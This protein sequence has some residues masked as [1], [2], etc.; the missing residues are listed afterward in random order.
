MTRTLEAI[1][2]HPLQLLI[3]I[4]LPPI[5]AVAVA[6]FMTP[7]TY[8]ST[9]SVWA[10]Q[11][12]FVIGATGPESNLAAFPAQTQATALTELLQTRTFA[13]AVAQTVLVAIMR[14]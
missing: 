14:Y 6:Y 3:L 9:A 13:L 2:R 10:L 12:Y 7:R 1:F 8:Q 5:I 11:R 4:I